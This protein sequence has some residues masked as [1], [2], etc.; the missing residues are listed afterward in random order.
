MCCEHLL[1]GEV[2][3]RATDIKTGESKEYNF[4]GEYSSDKRKSGELQPGFYAVWATGSYYVL[5]NS[6]GVHVEW[7]KKYKFDYKSDGRVLL[8]DSKPFLEYEK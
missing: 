3:Y 5:Y 1:N 6:N 4:L 2:P 7:D 8:N